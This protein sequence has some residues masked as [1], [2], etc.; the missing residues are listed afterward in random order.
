MPGIFDGL[1]KRSDTPIEERKYGGIYL[2]LSGLLFVGTM[3]SVIDEVSTRRPWKDTQARY[4]ALSEEGWRNTLA[5]ARAAVDSAALLDLLAQHD[6]LQSS[7]ESQDVVNAKAVVDRLDH[8]LLDAA[9]DVTF[10]KSKGDE[11]YYF[12]KKSVHDGTEDQALREKTA[13]L[14]GELAAAKAIVDSLT[15]A[16]STAAAVID[17]IM[18]R[19]KE[20]NR[21]IS[22]LLMPV[23]EAERKLDIA[24]NST[25]RIRQVMMNGYDRS[26]FG[27]PKARIDRC[28]TC[29][30]GWKDEMMADAAQPFTKHSVPELLKIH[31]PEVFGCTPCHRGQGAALTAGLAHGKDDHYWEWPLLPGKEVYASCNGCHENELYLK[32]G[33]EFNRG[34]QVLLESGCYGCH[35][36]KG[37]TDLPKIGPELGRLEEKARTGVALS[38]GEEPEG[39]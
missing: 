32:H 37:F 4:L 35:E 19:Q 25:I 24:S 3:W 16:R 22:E 15:G 6:S 38:L 5:E 29:H 33:G 8:E 23:Q 20:V 28:Q 30:S 7:M 11:A 12:W 27:T 1:N 36:I 14:G 10:A 9:R 18:T 31:D 26:N 2:L 39:V 17:G 34:K 13:R 21:K